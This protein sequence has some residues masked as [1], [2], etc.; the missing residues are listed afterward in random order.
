[1]TPSIVVAGLGRCG[2]SLTMQML[3]A[4]GVFTVGTFPAYEDAT[5][6]AGPG[7]AVKWLDP[8]RLRAPFRD[9]AVVIWLDRDV[10][11]QAKSQIKMIS[12]LYGGI[13]PIDADP[14]PMAMG[15]RRDRIKA[16]R[17]VDRYPVL[18]LTF[19]ELVTDPLTAAGNIALWLSRWF[20]VL[21]PERMADAVLPRGVEC[22]PDLAIEQRLVAQADRG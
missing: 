11:E 16:R 22:L 5:G 9:K 19:E 1:M 20:P 7:S 2:S 15:L 14:A 8:H 3:D 18:P 21:D 12:L 10:I 4:A 6:R 13:I 17:V